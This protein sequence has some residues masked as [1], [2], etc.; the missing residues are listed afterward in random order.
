MAHDA[1]RGDVQRA[2]LSTDPAEA[3]EIRADL[4]EHSAILSAGMTTLTAPGVFP[5]V[6][7]AAARVAP[8]VDTYIKV[9]GQTV[10]ATLATHRPPTV[11]TGFHDAFNPSSQGRQSARY[12]PRYARLSSKMACTP[13][14]LSGWV[15]SM[16]PG[17]TSM[18][19]PGMFISPVLPAAASRARNAR[20]SG[21]ML[22]SS[23]SIMFSSN[24][25]SSR[26]HGGPALGTTA[27][28]SMFST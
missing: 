25:S 3:D 17:V 23:P 4:G 6:R 12:C 28:A 22:I 15:T 16:A 1:I 11:L 27:L 26:K 13:G 21:K 18:V 20:W 24:R 7:A 10:D 19:V 8:E 2:L 14:S 5:D 9:A